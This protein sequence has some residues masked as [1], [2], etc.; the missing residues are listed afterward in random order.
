MA[1]AVEAG[2][3]VVQTADP[4]D[5]G[6]MTSAYRTVVIEPLARRR[7]RQANACRVPGLADWTAAVTPAARRAVSSV[8]L[9]SRITIARPSAHLRTWLV[10]RRTGIEL[11]WMALI[12]PPRS[13]RLRI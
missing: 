10:T 4:Y 2:G 12:S 13:C 7:A 1:V 3:G 11:G 5:L 8:T 6:Q 9:P